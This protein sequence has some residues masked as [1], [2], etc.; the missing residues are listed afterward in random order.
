MKRLTYS[1]KILSILA[2]EESKND[3]AV[4]NSKIASQRFRK[5][6]N[7]DGSVMRTARKMVSNKMVRR[8]SRGKFTLT[9]LGR[10]VIN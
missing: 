10:K 9:A 8:V 2:E 1:Q 7:I 4:F 6:R 5:V 3:N